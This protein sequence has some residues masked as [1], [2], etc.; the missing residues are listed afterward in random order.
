M[1]FC[2]HTACRSNLRHSPRCFMS[3]ICVYLAPCSATVSLR[4]DDEVV[5]AAVNLRLGLPMFRSHECSGCGATVGK[6]GTHALSCRCSKGRH[7]RHV[8][9]NDI[10]KRALDSIKI[11]CHLEP[12]VDMMGR[13][14]MVP[15]WCCAS[16]VL[17]WDATCADIIAP[18]HLAL[19]WL[20]VHHIDMQ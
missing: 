4:M 11:P 18:S 10:I 19:T 7:S 1:G 14:R 2:H 8:T 17:V 6:L 9:L 12:I 13:G 15:R 16:A 5:R 20:H 3:G